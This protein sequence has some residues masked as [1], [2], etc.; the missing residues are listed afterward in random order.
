M[1]RTILVVLAVCALLALMAGT[2]FAEGMGVGSYPNTAET[3]H[4]WADLGSGSAYFEGTGNPHGGFT[5]ATHNC[6]V[7]HSVHH[8]EL[9]GEALLPDTVAEACNYCHILPGTAGYIAIYDGNIANYTDASDFGHNAA[10]GAT[11]TS[12]H[13]V[14][15]ATAKMVSAAAYGAAPNILLDKI[16]KVD[17]SGT[18]LV[19]AGGNTIVFDG[20]E[21]SETAVSEWCTSCHR[22]G[23]GTY[24]YYNTAYNTMTHTMKDPTSDYSSSSGLIGTIAESTSIYC[25]SCHNRGEVDQAPVPPATVASQYNFPHWSDGVRFLTAATSLDATGV[26]DAAGAATDAHADGVCINCHRGMTVTGAGAGIG[27]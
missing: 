1:K 2:A 17:G 16:L 6:T 13:Q 25:S 3:G 26:P 19:D 21:T 27:W 12:C 11:C 4:T 18:D 24:G 20:T 22:D 8:A 5:V 14:H 9:A 7:C 10:G 15:A 23:T